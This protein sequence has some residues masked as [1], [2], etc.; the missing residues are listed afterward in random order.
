MVGGPVRMSDE[1][2]RC[3]DIVFGIGICGFKK[4]IRRGDACAAAAALISRR[5]GGETHPCGEGVSRSID[6]VVG[7]QRIVQGIVDELC[8]LLGERLY[9]A[10]CDNGRRVMEIGPEDEGVSRSLVDAVPSPGTA[11][12]CVVIR[13]VGGVARHGDDE[14]AILLRK[15]LEDLLLQ[16]H[17]IHDGKGSTALL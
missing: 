16:K 6:V 3:G 9:I 10:I 12:G 13:V 1:G 7:G 4:E 2:L 5:Y 8:E 17:N 11:F 14:L 15:L